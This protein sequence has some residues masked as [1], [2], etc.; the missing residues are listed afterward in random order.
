VAVIEA[1]SFDGPRTKDAVKLLASLG[2]EGKA[3]VVVSRE[4]DNATLSFRNLTEVKVILSSELNAYDVLCSDWLVF[5]EASLPGDDQGST[6]VT[7]TSAASA[8]APVAEP[9]PVAAESP[10]ETPAQTE[11]DGQ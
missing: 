6:T 8:P 2:V 3:L 11:E 5:T 9:A 4:D 1:W 10:A 7:A